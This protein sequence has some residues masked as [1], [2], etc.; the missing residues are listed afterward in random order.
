MK[1]KENQEGAM[2][3]QFQWSRGNRSPDGFKGDLEGEE[4]QAAFQ[5]IILPGIGAGWGGRGAAE[6][7]VASIPRCSLRWLKWTLGHRGQHRAE[8]FH[9][10][11]LTDSVGLDPHLNSQQ[12]ATLPT[13]ERRI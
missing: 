6:R 12:K 2:P 7:W 13:Y 10:G 4:M 1:Q 9:S 5:G 11:S 8:W 3:E